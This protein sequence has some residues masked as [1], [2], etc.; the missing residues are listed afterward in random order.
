MSLTDVDKNSEDRSTPI[1]NHTDTVINGA[2]KAHGTLSSNYTS[3]A[4]TT[5]V[6]GTNS[7]TAGGGKTVASGYKQLV[8]TV[9]VTVV[10]S[11]G[12]V[13]TATL[14]HPLGYVPIVEASL[15]NATI[16]TA[17]GSVSGASLPL[18]GFT[19]ADLSTSNEI[20]FATWLYAFADINNIYVNMLNTT[21]SPI[22]I[23]VTCS[24]YRR[25]SG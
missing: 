6:G 22:S 4:T 24:L 3:D 13:T 5:P 15:D 9:P 2:T 7:G 12:T 18:P 1:P 25:V 14:A 11:G 17:G 10:N 23:T 16:S 8:L 21:G 20:K 19:S